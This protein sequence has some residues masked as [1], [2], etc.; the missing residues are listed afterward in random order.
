M[1][2]KI[3]TD[4]TA[5]ITN[6]IKERLIRVPLTVRFGEEEF[7]DGVTINHEEF[8]KKMAESEVLPT[9]SQAAP[10]QFADAFKNATENGDSVVAI[11]VSA[12]LSGTYQSA[13]IAAEEFPGKVFVVDSKSVAIGSGIL[14]E[15]ALTLMDKGLSAKEIAEVLEKERENIRL[16][17]VLDTLEN[18]K[19]G[20]RISKTAAF[21]GELLS[22][23][24]VISVLDGSIDIIGK[25]RGLKQG[26]SMLAEEI[27][28]LGIDFDKP[29]LLGY[30][31]LD[32]AALDKFIDYSA[33]LWASASKNL[34]KTPIC[35]VIGTH[36]GAGAY[37]VA[38]FKK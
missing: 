4:S 28:A 5:D 20:G 6:E 11:T 30:T 21:A 3:L 31:G 22:I 37:A 13:L 36:A 35:S 29:F 19:K 14:A 38:F 27:E 16:F 18:L 2:V 23:K 17:A 9:T 32:K 25:A 8:Y 12:K 10:F 7:I 15:L 26:N 33:D 1:S 34:R 24:P